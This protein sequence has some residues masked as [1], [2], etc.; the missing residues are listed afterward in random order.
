MELDL[1]AI[2]DPTI[3]TFLKIHDA[4]LALQVRP[5]QTQLCI[6]YADKIPVDEASGT[7]RSGILSVGSGQREPIG[8]LGAP[9]SRRI[10]AS[11]KTAPEEWTMSGLRSISATSG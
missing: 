2:G 10:R 1:V 3:D 7:R 11:T 9:G 8:G 4:H 6:D 5:D